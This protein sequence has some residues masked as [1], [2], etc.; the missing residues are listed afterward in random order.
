MVNSWATF[1]KHVPETTGLVVPELTHVPATTDTDS[2]TDEPFKG[3]FCFRSAPGYKR[4]R[5]SFAG[6]R[7]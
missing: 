4:T 3:V 2:T 5:N 7:S 1:G 6:S